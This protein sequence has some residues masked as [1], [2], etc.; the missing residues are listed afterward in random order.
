MLNIAI[1]RSEFREIDR[2]REREK[3]EKRKKKRE[4]YH[5]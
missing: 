1:Y 3:K 4:I 2:E 5:W